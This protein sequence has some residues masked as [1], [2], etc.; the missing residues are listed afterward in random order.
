MHSNATSTKGL[1]PWIL[2]VT[3]AV[4][5]AIVENV[6]FGLDNAR[7]PGGCSLLGWG[8]V[9]ICLGIFLFGGLICKVCTT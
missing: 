6:L 5:R 1:C 9:Y 7:A 4:V 8:E 3:A 2:D